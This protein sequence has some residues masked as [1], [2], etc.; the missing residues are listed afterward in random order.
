MTDKGYIPW[1]DRIDEELVREITRDFVQRIY[2]EAGMRV[3]TTRVNWSEDGRDFDAQT[4]G[5]PMGQKPP[6]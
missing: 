6:S 2:K 4:F 5:R 1:H 3:S